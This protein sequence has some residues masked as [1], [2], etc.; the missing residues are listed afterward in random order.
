MEAR[1]VRRHR[2]KGGRAVKVDTDSK[3]FMS[4]KTVTAR[5]LYF[6]EIIVFRENFDVAKMT[7]SGPP[8]P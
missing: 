3:W 7:P 8:Q 4:D 1:S 5:V 2:D 6:K